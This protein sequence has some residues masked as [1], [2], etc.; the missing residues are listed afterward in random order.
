[1]NNEIYKLNLNLY[2]KNNKIYKLE[3]ASNILL[4][5]FSDKPNGIGFT[6][7]EKLY[8]NFTNLYL[9][10]D[11]IDEIK[12]KEKNTYPIQTSIVNSLKNEFIKII[13]TIDNLNYLIDII[14]K[15][16]NEVHREIRKTII[17]KHDS[18]EKNEADKIN[19]DER[20]IN[21]INTMGYIQKFKEKLR[22]KNFKSN[23]KND[24]KEKIK[25]FT[26]DQLTI[27]NGNLKDLYN[28]DINFRKEINK[29][30]QVNDNNLKD[31]KNYEIFVN[32]SLINN[33]FIK[34]QEL[35]TS[36]SNQSYYIQSYER[37]IK[38]IINKYYKY[39]YPKKKIENILEND[40]NIKSIITFNNILY[41]LK[42]IYLK[43]NTIVLLDKREK[44]FVK[45]IS[46][47]ENNPENFIANYILSGKNII[48][49][50][51]RID[52]QKIDKIKLLNINYIAK[53]KENNNN[54]TNNFLKYNPQD[55]DKKYTNY[56]NIFFD[57]NIEYYNK[58]YSSLIREENI[59]KL[60]KNKEEIFFNNEVFK[61]LNQKYKPAQEETKKTQ[62]T[63]IK[64]IKFILKNILFDN[65]T[66]IINN[67]NYIVNDFK[68][69]DISNNTNT[70]INI[71]N[72]VDNEKSNYYDKKISDDNRIGEMQETIRIK[73]LLECFEDIDNNGKISI[74]RKVLA[75]NCSSR[76][77]ILDTYFTGNLYN[78]FNIPGKYLKNKLLSKRKK[79]IK[80]ENNVTKKQDKRDDNKDDNKDDKNDD[81]KGG[82]KNR[83]FT[84][85]KKQKFKINKKSKKIKKIK[86]N[87]KK[88]KK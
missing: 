6:N 20:F 48:T 19:N 3:D 85:K 21:L 49:L 83:K 72:I 13:D 54:L 24:I 88:S 55:F 39:I 28:K 62:T 58:N 80:K 43:E 41:I 52:L 86:K 44:Y 1:M 77:E 74:K 23:I 31:K 5:E 15:N 25:S 76:A 12:S 4:E 32:Q 59:K 82:K 57:K 34:M 60:I 84:Y 14:V 73:I 45:N 26:S 71:D 38:N 36:K 17:T 87:Q 40:D 79:Q 75:N 53:D 78:F 50:N 37:E 64:N 16:N 30:Y 18:V 69:Y 70:S 65:K 2:D 56:Q 51:L 61:I 63:I 22:E 42:N 47:L 11:I 46:L 27:L 35:K 81:K 29:I 33:L 66:I 67:N 10:K 7:N 9:N 68:I 8:M